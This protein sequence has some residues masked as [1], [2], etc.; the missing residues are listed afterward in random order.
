M[1]KLLLLLLIA[2]VLMTSSVFGDLS[3][4]KRTNSSPA[5]PDEDTD[6]EMVSE[7]VEIVVSKGIGYYERKGKEPEERTEIIF[8]VSAQFEMHNTGEQ[9]IVKMYYPL[10]VGGFYFEYENWEDISKENDIHIIS[11]GEEIEWQPMIGIDTYRLIEFYDYMEEFHAII[12]EPYDIII[13]PTGKDLCLWSID[14]AVGNNK[15]FS[16]LIIVFEISFEHD[17]TKII[18]VKYSQNDLLRSGDRAY[19]SYLLSTGATW[20][21]NI[22]Y[23]K[24]TL[25]MGEGMTQNDFYAIQLEESE[26]GHPQVFEDFAVWEFFNYEPSSYSNANKTSYLEFAVLN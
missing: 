13:G 17:E 12:K 14:K 26:L 22:G 19:F 5:S 24:I 18:E 15:G 16:A 6:V 9:Q 7:D 3:N 4:Y 23:G 2:F 21:G 1:V 8:K 10:W 20:K 25:Y 11:N